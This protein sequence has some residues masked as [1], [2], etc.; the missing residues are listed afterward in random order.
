MTLTEF[1]A[2]MLMGLIGSR[3]SIFFEDRKD[4]KKVRNLERSFGDLELLVGEP[5]GKGCSP[6]L[7]W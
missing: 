1:A 3:V 6:G 4:L 7:M 2:S 5:D